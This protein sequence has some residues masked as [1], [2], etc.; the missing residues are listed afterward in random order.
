MTRRSS[1]GW[2]E[3]I[4]GIL[5][6]ILGIYSAGQPIG[7]LL[8]FVIVYAIV[9]LITGIADIVV[10]IRLRSRAGASSWVTLV[11]GIISIICGI[12]LLVNPN[13]GAWAL[14]FLFPIWFIV[15]CINRLANLGY[16]RETAGNGMYWFTLIVN[17]ISIILGIMLIFMPG[18]AALTLS[19]L[20]SFYLILAGV[21]SI[22]IGIS[23]I[24]E[25]RS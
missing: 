12:L 23:T 9:A 19:F 25:G 1:Y 11:T 6:I 22:G 5:L 16:I 21:S 15:H 3:L 24:G 4:L 18:A 14:S 17:V 20:I 10:F 7:T 8:G 2:I 13:A